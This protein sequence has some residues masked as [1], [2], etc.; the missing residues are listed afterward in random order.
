LVAGEE[1]SEGPDLVSVGEEEESVR[2]E[3]GMTFN[4]SGKGHAARERKE[5]G[6]RECQ[7]EEVRCQLGD[8]LRTC[9]GQEI[10]D[11]DME[12]MERELWPRGG[13]LGQEAAR[14]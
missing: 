13:Q 8:S 11:I 2:Y 5:W 7:R 4:A 1:D 14:S 12:E 3:R 9:R 6:E 10:I